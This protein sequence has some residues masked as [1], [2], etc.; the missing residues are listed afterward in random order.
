MSVV[1]FILAF[2]VVR[3]LTQ[4]PL[5]PSTNSNTQNS[6][7]STA[8]L[9]SETVKRVKAGMTLPTKV[10]VT[11]MLVDVTAE[12]NAI[13]YHYILS[14]IDTSSLS[15]EYLKNYLGTS[16]CKNTDTKIYLIEE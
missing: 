1:V 11:T 15:N 10:D 13:R 2:A 8:E 5:S 3:Y 14:G 7:Y 9:V 4:Q 12:P 6:T 16:L